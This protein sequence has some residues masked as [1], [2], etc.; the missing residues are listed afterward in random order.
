[1]VK[2]V[3]CVFDRQTPF[4]Y[5]AGNIC[6]NQSVLEIETTAKISLNP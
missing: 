3:E 6:F 4:V 2:K 5:H 1:M